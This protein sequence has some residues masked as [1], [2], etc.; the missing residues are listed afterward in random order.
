LLQDCQFGFFEILTFFERL[1]LFLERKKARQN[2][3]FFSQKGLALE[4]RVRAVY[5]YN[6]LLKRVYNHAKR[7]EYWKKFTFALKMISVIDNVAAGGPTIWTS[8]LCMDWNQCIGIDCSLILPA[9]HKPFTRSH[10][11]FAFVC[12][13]TSYTLCWM[14]FSVRLS[15]DVFTT[16]R[17]LASRVFVLSQI[18]GVPWASSLSDELNRLFSAIWVCFYRGKDKPPLVLR[19][20]KCCRCALLNVTRNSRAI[21][22]IESPL[23]PCLLRVSSSREP[24]WRFRPLL[25]QS[26]S[27]S[28]IELVL[29]TETRQQ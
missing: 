22:S 27:D 10:C 8:S 19:V 29:Q 2:L 11:L 12:R 9:G 5:P 13:S 25:G 4:K 28:L 26:E 17:S 21:N 6:S 15:V 16:T 24:E 1:W 3:T 23:N 14:G 7:A 18:E 20:D